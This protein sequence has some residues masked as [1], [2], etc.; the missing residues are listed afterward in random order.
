MISSRS[1]WQ[2]RAKRSSHDSKKSQL[3]IKLRHLARMLITKKLV[4]SLLIRK[5][6]KENKEL[7]IGKEERLKKAVVLKS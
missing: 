7:L 5:L 2:I 3:I 4:R 1:A 6:T